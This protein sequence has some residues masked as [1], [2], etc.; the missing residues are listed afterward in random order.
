[1]YD[2]YM[3]PPPVNLAEVGRRFGISKE[4]VRQIFVEH[5]HA[6]RYP[7]PKNRPSPKEVQ[8]Q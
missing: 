5:G 3:G 8:K 1:M 2:V 6:V 7:R 4:R